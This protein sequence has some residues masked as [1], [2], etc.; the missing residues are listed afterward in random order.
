MGYMLDALDSL[1]VNSVEKICI[2]IVEFALEHAPVRPIND[3]LGVGY[4]LFLCG[5]QNQFRDIV[6]VKY[7]M[8]L[9]MILDGKFAFVRTLID[10]TIINRDTERIDDAE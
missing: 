6:V 4:V 7:I 3:C 2:E 9:N 8:E 10:Q 1:G 5:K